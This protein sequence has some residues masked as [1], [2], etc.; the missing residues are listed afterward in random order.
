MSAAKALDRAS[1]RMPSRAAPTSCTSPSAFVELH[2]EQGRDLVDRSAPVGVATAIR[3]HGRWRLDLHGRADHAGT[4][5]LPDRDDP[6]L[7]LAAAVQAARAE[8]ERAGTVATI[9]RLEVEPNATNAIPSRVRAWLDARGADEY[10]VRA[11]VAS[12]GA[13][14]G[15]EPVEESWTADGRVPADLA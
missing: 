7:R 10:V 14:A 4:T 13:A 12:V 15:V 6:M 8:A 9:G 5:R 2:V 3:P 11:L 1:L